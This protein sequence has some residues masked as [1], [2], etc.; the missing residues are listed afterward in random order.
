MYYCAE[1][2]VE[3]LYKALQPAMEK[4]GMENIQ[5][6]GVGAP[7]GN[8]HTGI[9]EYAPNLLWKGV[10]P[11]AQMFTERFGIPCALTN[12]ANAAAVGEM[13]YGAARGMKDFIVPPWV[14]GWAAALYVMDN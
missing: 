7:N 10:V 12:D 5:G 13:L 8:M 3:D 14:R 1:A 4:V 6:I 11:L 9:I 2:F